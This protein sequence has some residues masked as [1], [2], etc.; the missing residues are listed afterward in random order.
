MSSPKDLICRLADSIVADGN[1]AHDLWTWLPSHKW[2]VECYEDY[3]INFMPEALSV[4]MQEAALLL[5][6]ARGGPV[7]PKEWKPFLELEDNDG[8]ITS[9]T[10]SH[11]EDLIHSC[12]E[13]M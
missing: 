12:L 10:D 1:A 9:P 7:D 8:T 4:V 11:I 2:A 13:T 3:A 5:S 6:V